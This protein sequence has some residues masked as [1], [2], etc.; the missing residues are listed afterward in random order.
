MRPE[1]R[2][3]RDRGGGGDGRRKGVAIAVN[4]GSVN[5]TEVGVKILLCEGGH[6]MVECIYKKQHPML[7]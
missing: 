3:V 6:K 1:G 7:A 5:R 4:D 2:G